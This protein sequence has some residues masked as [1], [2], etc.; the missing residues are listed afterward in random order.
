MPAVYFTVQWPDGEQEKCYSPSTIVHQHFKVGE[1]MNLA[2]F[3]SRAEQSLE[4]ASNR[5]EQ[6]FGYYCSSA[7]DQLG[8][9]RARAASYADWDSAQ[10]TIID[11]S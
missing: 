4:Q 1:A 5:V 6:K 3:V 10:V 11:L 8:Q 7:L 2:E 9:I